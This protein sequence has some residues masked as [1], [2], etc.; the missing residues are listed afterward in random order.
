M[1]RA[2]WMSFGRIALALLLLRAQRVARPTAVP[3]R[4]SPD[5]IGESALVGDVDGTQPQCPRR[6]SSDTIWIADWTFDAPDGGCDDTGWTKIDNRILNDGSNYWRIGTE[7]D[8]HERDRRQGGDP[9]QARPLLGP[10]PGLR[11]QLGLL[12]H[13]QVPWYGCHAV[14][15]LRERQRARL[16]LLHGRGRLGRR[17]RVPCELRHRSRGDFGGSRTAMSCWH[18]TGLQST[19]SVSALVLPDYGL[20]TVTHE[21]YIRFASDGGYSD[22]DGL[23]PDLLGRGPRRRQHRRHGRALLHGELRRRA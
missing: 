12:D 13:L 3:Q 16:R 19:G 22:E 17:V 5:D 8:G 23:Y 9:L 14:V 7:F 18:S 15:Q 20:P 4:S 6:R 11:Q 10:S 1:K 21:V 2:S